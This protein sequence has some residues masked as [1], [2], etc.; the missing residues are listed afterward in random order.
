MTKENG[1]I[2]VLVLAALGMVLFTVLFIVTG[3]QVYFQNSNY[4]VQAE[5]ASAL[6]EAGIDKAIASI[7]ATGG[8]YNGEVET[9][10]GDG[11][12]SVAVSNKDTATVL[13]KSTGY[14]PNK[15]KPK[16]QRT[17]NIQ[18]SKGTGISFIYGM[19][20]GN[21]GISM[22]NNSTI[23][24]SVYSNNNILG[25]NNELITGDVYV[26]GGTQAQADQQSDCFSPNCRDLIF[27]RNISGSDLLDVAQSFKPQMT[28]AINKVSLKLKKIGSPSNLAVRIL[29][30]SGGNPNKNNVLAFGTLPASLVTDQ[31][32]FVDATFNSTPTLAANTPYWILL[33]TSLDNSNYWAWSED[34]SQG[35]TNGYPLWS[36]NWQ[37]K[38][39]VWNN[40]DGDLGFKTWMGG[41]A[42]SLSMGNGSVVRGSVHANTVNGIT[43]QKDAYYQTISNSTVR[44]TSY[45]GS[46]DPPPVAMPISDSDIS[47]WQAGAQKY[48]IISATDING[49]PARLGPGKIDA[50][51]TTSSNC[52]IT[53]TTPIW[54]TKNLNFGNSTVFRMDPS[55]GATSGV[56]IV[57]GLTTFQ[58]S[59]DLLGT[60]TPG[61]YL[62]LLSTYNSQFSGEAAIN[63][64]NSSITGI[65]Y[66]PYGT[67]VLSNNANFKEIVASQ[68][69][70]G[71]DTTLT[72]DSGLASTF[73]SSGPS[74]SY[75]IVKGTYQTK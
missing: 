70:M 48:G 57:D 51:V 56:I 37:D 4:S 6:A 8:S 9:F 44:G 27:G 26:A 16:V 30:D 13:I 75:S 63:T 7:N 38:N 66:A 12:Y 21:G 34:L 54:I 61:S 72:Y 59:D 69:N 25:G 58:N 55:M 19:L 41:V 65:L 45:P 3:A 43:I 23:N 18:A 74:G 10:L 32:G 40:I 73:F 15:Q 53:V 62:T 2:L 14:V 24:G 39:P 1:Q 5:K 67:I 11:S 50:N 46:A 20:V 68:I 49:C 42:T 64:G 71:I 31:Y 36:P 47:S 17:I 29:A 52:T 22:G 35:Y 28:A 60:G 33:D